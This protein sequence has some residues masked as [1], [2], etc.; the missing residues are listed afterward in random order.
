[1]LPERLGQRGFSIPED[2]SEEQKGSGGN[3]YP[4]A[5]LTPL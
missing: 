2:G 4:K 5:K 3:Y 1:M